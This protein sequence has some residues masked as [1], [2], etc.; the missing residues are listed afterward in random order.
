MYKS[1]NKLYSLL[2]SIFLPINVVSLS[3]QLLKVDVANN[4]N[5]QIPS[6]DPHVDW[7]S[8]N[9]LFLVD[10]KGMV[11]FGGKRT[12]GIRYAPINIQDNQIILEVTFTPY[13]N[14]YAW[15]DGHLISITDQN[16]NTVCRLDM[17]RRGRFMMIRCGKSAISPAVNWKG[18]NS[19]KLKIVIGKEHTCLEMDNKTLMEIK[20]PKIALGKYKLC[21]GRLENGNPG[22]IGWYAGWS[23]TTGKYS[24]SSKQIKPNL[25][26][27]RVKELLALE[28]EILISQNNKSTVLDQ[29][30]IRLARR[31]AARLALDSLWAK[32]YNNTMLDKFDYYVTELTE[33]VQ[34]INQPD[35]TDDTFSISM[36]ADKEK[37]LGKDDRQFYFGVCGWSLGCYMKELSELGF[38]LVSTTVWPD[39]IFDTNGNINND[40]INARILPT[41]DVANRY[42][43]KVDVLIAPYTPQYLLKQYPQWDAII[44]GHGMSE[45][46]LEK[47]EKSKGRIAGHGFL[48]ASIIN[49]EYRKMCRNFVSYVTKKLKNYPALASYCLANEPQ[50]ED[51]STPMQE[52]FRKFLKQKYT[53]I[54]L[55]NSVWETNYP[56][57][58]EIIMDRT[59]SYNRTNN[60]R[61]MDWVEF[62]WKTGSEYIN[63]L[64]QLVIKDNS[65][66]TTHAKTLPYEFGMPWMKKN[67]SARNFY[68]YADG[69]NRMNW[70]RITSII[71]TDTWA[72]NFNDRSAPVYQSMYLE[73][74][75]SYTDQAIPIFDS[76][77]HIINTKKPSSAQFVSMIMQLNVING[78]RAGAL[79]V[80]HPLVNQADIVSSAQLLLT[81]GKTAVHIRSFSKEFL[82]LANR[83]RPIAI[84]YSPT[85]K[86]LQGDSYTLAVQRL[87]EVG[88]STG[89]GI[90]M[91]DERQ[92]VAGNTDGIKAIITINCAKT[93]EKT[94]VAL[95]D[96]AKKGGQVIVLGEFATKNKNK[97]SMS[98]M[99]V[100]H[101]PM[102]KDFN[103]LYMMFRGVG[104]VIDKLPTTE[105]VSIQ[106]KPIEGLRWHTTQDAGENTLLFIA[107]TNLQP[108]TFKINSMDRIIN[109]ITGKES[110][111]TK[112]LPS[113]GVFFGLI[114]KADSDNIL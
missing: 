77:W 20:T 49:P 76:E 6:I 70:A 25:C 82:T 72:D 69:V 110:L 91:I 65:H 68:D 52:Q 40:Y 109:I 112:T 102:A 58:T 50:F 38:N 62:N 88:L 17:V 106:N 80:G 10:G 59:N 75:R 104:S 103:S 94:P 51:Y 60:V 24:G 57:W 15:M 12:G 83:A 67:S 30:S 18:G 55:L 7:Q 53:N 8:I 34:Q 26:D 63:F 97:T 81:T 45:E 16:S 36:P 114:K 93:M 2:L 28:Q 87:F 32:L 9:K 105:I 43:I 11:N 92:L 42:G 111:K 108:V 29:Y 27:P 13:E 31:A 79:W 14:F 85:A 78:L 35:F 4:S 22:A 71:G 73:L 44:A 113:F 89:L 98:S 46:I 64:N 95:G 99:R 5:L 3:A 86:Y 96:F 23:V 21:I 101:L 90:T 19:R 37:W 41:L 56:N 66:I 74:L 33:M 54:T 47:H 48:K 1:N 84:L 107:N 39:C 100:K 61:F